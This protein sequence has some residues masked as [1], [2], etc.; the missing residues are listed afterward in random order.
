MRTLAAALLGLVLLAP[1]VAEAGRIVDK[2]KIQIDLGGDVKGF[3]DVLFPYEHLLMPEDPV[4][5]AAV[6]FRFK[7][8][9]DYS[10]WLS[11]ELHHSLTSRFRPAGDSAFGLSAGT[12]GTVAEEAIPLSYELVDTPNFALDGRFDRLNVSFHVP[13]FDATVGRQPISFGSGLFFTPMDLL[14]PYTPQVVDR[15]YKPGVD[16]IRLDGYF[17]ATGRATG[18]VGVV[19]EFDLEGLFVAGYGGFTVVITDINFFAA[20]IQQ[21]LVLGAG[22]ATSIGPVSVHG[23]LTVT[24]PLDGEESCKGAVDGADPDA[25][26]PAF[27]RGVVGATARTNFGL[28][29]MGEL[30][31]QTTGTSDDTA[32]LKVATRER[33]ARGELWTMGKFYGGFSISQEIL[34]ILIVSATAMVNWLDPSALIGP[35][36]SWSVAD[37]VD[38]AIGGF[39]TLGKRPPEVDVLD[40]IDPKT[41][42]PVSEEEALEIIESASEFGLAPS[43]AYAQMR[44][45]F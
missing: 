17:G 8:S 28:S 9:G 29:V 22:V 6:D 44:F 20:K 24:V 13:G 31:A 18:V 36:L 4:A 12:Q 19:D 26:C 45:Y 39:V 11:W 14:A 32:Y 2:E 30:Y 33:F 27:V 25:R 21:D 42:Q 34:P 16:A 43:Q 5:T 3:F 40:L 37:N 23:D 7:F 15:E 41:F 10:T 38:F 35:S 1:A